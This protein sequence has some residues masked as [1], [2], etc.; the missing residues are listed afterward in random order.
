MKKILFVAP[1]LSTG[2]LPQYLCKKIEKLKGNLEIFCVEYDAITGGVLVVQRDKI[3]HMLDSSHFITL[4][5]DKSKLIG[6]IN[7]IKPDYIHLEE[8]P[9]YFMNDSITDQIYTKDRKYKLFETSHDSSFDPEKNKR[10]FPDAFLFVSQWQIDQYRNI[11]VPKYLV[12]YPIEYKERVNREEGLSKL[13]LDPN[14]KHVLNVG[15]FTPR[16]NQAE[17]FAVARAMEDQNVEFHFVGNQ[18]DNFKGYW[19]PL[20][21]HK[22]NNCRIWG[23][24]K[25]VS[26]FYSCMDLFLFT[27]RGTGN[28]KE[29]MP[30]VL[31]E[32][33]GWNIP[34]LMY[35]LD[36]YQ[37]YFNS[38]PSVKYLSGNLTDDCTLIS[39][40]L[41]STMDQIISMPK[42]DDINI[43]YDSISKRF[44]VE[45][46]GLNKELVGKNL[47]CVLSDS[48]NGLTN[49]V[50]EQVYGPGISFWFMTNGGEP[51]FNGY[52]VEIFVDDNLLYSNLV[53][54]FQRYNKIIPTVLGEEIMISH[55]KFDYSAWWT[56]MEVFRNVE[57]PGLKDGDVVLDVGSN[58]G[59]FTLFALDNGASKVYSVEPSDVNFPHLLKNTES[60]GDKVT[61]IQK[62]I[63][64]TDSDVEFF[65]NDV[66][67]IH[68][69]FGN[70]DNVAG[71][72][73]KIT[74]PGTTI[75]TLISDNNIQKI[76]YLKVDCEGGEYAL[77]ENISEDFLSKKVRTIVCEVHSF[78]GSHFEYETKI[79]AKLIRCGFEVTENA[80]LDTSPILMMYANRKPRIKIVHML[81]NLTDERESKSIES[82]SKMI[83]FGYK[84]E[85]SI[86]EL[87]REKP[88]VE[89]CLRPFAVSETPGDYLLGPGHYGCY[90][91][92]R[93]GITE[94]FDDYT[95]AILLNECDSILQF[96]PRESSE[97]IQEGYEM[98]K[99][100]D[101]AYLSFGKRIVNYP[102]EH[103]ESD[104]FL[105]GR[106]SE[107]H[108]ILITKEKAQYFKDKFENTPWDVSDLW[109][110]AFITDYRKGIFSR[111]YS[112]QY[113]G[114]SNIDKKFKDGHIIEEANSTLSST[115]N[116]DISVII[117][118]CDKYDFLWRGWYLSFKNH[119]NWDLEWPIYFCNEKKDLPFNDDRIQQ[120]KSDGEDG[121]EGFSTRLS[122][123]LAK[124]KTKYVLYIQDDMW[125]ILDV[126]RDVMIGALHTIKHFG[127]NSIK[128]HQ[129]IWY[130]YSL[131]KTNLFIKDKRVLKYD[132][133][134]EYLLTHN[135]AIWN[136]EFLQANMLTGEDPWKNEF[137]GTKR[138]ADTEGDVAIYHYDYKW[139]YQPGVC[140]GGVLN[141]TGREMLKQLEATELLKTK[142]DL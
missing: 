97:K 52:K 139:Y 26:N 18:A 74:M 60:F 40:L 99:K 137:D 70:S 66:S 25:D 50:T 61:T 7:K 59:Y 46:K 133:N 119:W 92:H 82:L 32:A 3:N 135:A 122:D 104:L 56:F 101:L 71:E 34:I 44:S 88:P 121:P 109:Y 42:E 129:K 22:P 19:E 120:I 79:K 76:D 113:A 30:L 63:N 31:R 51:N 11:D 45:I 96:S 124:I 48:Y 54:D 138:M 108:C 38:Y 49:Y 6:L 81:N 8:I 110:N 72:R 13:G 98:C 86:T 36:V 107:A 105:T 69:M 39:T 20:M 33:L 35:N 89:N 37:N 103:V 132:K 91:A 106:L 58:L 78:A 118:T 65:V 68:T 4:S 94:Y 55:D 16:K 67:S 126:D 14:K 41:G 87:Y 10:Y 102:H 23:E 53:V 5:N 9:E 95:D 115:E 100:Y 84:Y 83:T 142:F 21:R 47:K 12:E 64:Y 57:Y 116:G 136:R 140:N 85:Q 117:Q 27:S 130:S 90:M 80:N 17:I 131:L 123:I 127:F 134:S 141:E 1:H 62:A 114:V 75:S 112:L 73:K 24:R 93:K 128:M 2:G 111:P 28:D 77:F 125:P 15:L 43:G 29:T